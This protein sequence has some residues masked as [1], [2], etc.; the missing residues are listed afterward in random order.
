MTELYHP[1]SSPRKKKKEKV[2]NFLPN[3]ETNTSPPQLHPWCQQRTI[4]S[5]CQN[6]NI[7]I[8]AYSPIVRN[9]KAHDP[10]AVSLAQKH[11]KT[12][13]QILIRYCL[14]KGWVPLPKS[15]TPSRIEEN[16][17]VFGFELSEGD[18]G[19]LDGLDQGEAGAIVQAVRN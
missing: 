14:Q 2:L 16:A 17:D 15:D 5:Y 6:H 1:S 13:S 8:Q 9:Q 3:T 10:T 7:T 18:M 12:V 4:V 11:S 19:V